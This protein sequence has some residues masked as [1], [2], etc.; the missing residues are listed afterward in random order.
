M[1]TTSKGTAATGFWDIAGVLVY[2]LPAAIVMSA[3]EM[4]DAALAW[5]NPQSRQQRAEA[6]R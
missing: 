6:A 5:S 3:D 1:S 4:V 2:R